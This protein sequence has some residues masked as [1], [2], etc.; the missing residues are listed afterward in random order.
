M[1]VEPYLFYNGRCEEAI[2]FYKAVLGAEVVMQ[3]RM[4]E[5]PQPPP[6][7][8]TPP[9]FEHKIMHATLRI[10]ETLLMMSDGDS[11]KPSDFN[12]FCLS[13]GVAD[14]PEAQRVFQALQVDGKVT[15]PL[16][17]TFFSPCFGMLK[18]RFG[19]GWMVIVPTA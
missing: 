12:G 14:A 16:G 7:G 2:A 9:G 10:G 5:S 11:A 8:M 1:K 15:M 17:Q 4:D 6:P 13:L 19:V 3:M 18:D